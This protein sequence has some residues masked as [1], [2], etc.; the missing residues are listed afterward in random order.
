M[1]WNTA[2]I[3]AQEKRIDDFLDSLDGSYAVT[4]EKLCFESATGM[5]LPSDSFAYLEI[6]GR[7]FVSGDALHYLGD[8]V[9]IRL[10]KSGE[11]GGFYLASVISAYGYKVFSDGEVS[12]KWA[13]G[14]DETVESWNIA[15]PYTATDDEIE[16]AKLGP[17]KWFD[18][19][20]LVLNKFIDAIGVAFDELIEMEMSVISPQP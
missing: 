1:G 11:G 20:T 8:S 16:V 14:D 7:L 4:D 5:D 15:E 10:S 9:L 3:V 19:E 13:K 18:G 17:N 2:L 6:N 12:Q